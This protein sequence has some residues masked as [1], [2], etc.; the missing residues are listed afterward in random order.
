M[1]IS[2]ATRQAGPYFGDDVT[3][4]FPF[5]F[6]VFSASDL[7]II[8]TDPTGAETVLTTGFS[9]SLNADQNA[10]PGGTVTLSSVL[11][12]GYKLTLTSNVAALQSTDLTNQGGFYPAVITNALDRLTILVQQIL[13]GL[14]RSLKFPISD[15]AVSTTLPTV[16]ARANRVLGFDTSGA[17]ATYDVSVTALNVTRTLVTNST[18]QDILLSFSYTP[19]VNALQVFKNGV[20]LVLGTGYTE[21]DSTNIRLSIALISSDVL[22]VHGGQIVPTG[23]VVTTSS[24]VDAAVTSPKI[25]D[26]AVSANKLASGAVTLDKLDTTGGADTTLTGQG[27]G[28]APSWV[29]P[30]K[31][32]SSSSA[33]A[34]SNTLSVSIDP[35][36]W[37]FRTTTGGTI[38]LRRLSSAATLTVPSGATLGTV[39]GRASR[40]A[41]LAL[42]NNGVVEPAVVNTAGG[43]N[44]DETTLIN[45]SAMS[46]SANSNA[47][48]YSAVARTGVPF[49]VISY[50]DST[51]LTAGTW[52]STPVVTPHTNAGR[53]FLT[54]SAAVV[55]GGAAIDFTGIPSWARRVTLM[56]RNASTNGVSLSIVQLGTAS[57][58]E[59]S[60]YQST[61][62]TNGAQATATTG[63]LTTY[64]GDGSNALNGA[65]VFTLLDPVNS[66]W[67][68]SGSTS[69]AGASLDASVLAGGKQLGG[70]LTRLR[71]TTVGG[72]DVYDNTG[73]ASL[74]WE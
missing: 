70:L 55:L 23:S 22:E 35:G 58:F 31:Q 11:S 14:G 10:N 20:K 65:L 56:L 44:L 62:S 16:A 61:A 63:F 17:F 30:R 50:L 54:T 8:K 28:N 64:R 37:D 60:G 2:S 66:V 3:L 47:T 40:I 7:Q 4:A 59:N 34:V 29:P 43:F 1:T 24:I 68:M 9:T 46:G 73:S 32:L 18:A 45:T 69:G 39:S 27:S 74:M 21:T 52:A 41:L 67:V 51:Q 72:V 53:T 57:A 48:V 49:R 19:G 6:K 25:A 12:S 36:A 42:D 13:N 15:S 33:N 5:A 38:N 71:L 26:G